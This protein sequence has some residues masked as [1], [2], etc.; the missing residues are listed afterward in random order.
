MWR[1][2]LLRRELL[3][4][5]FTGKPLIV[6][7]IENECLF[8]E[9]PE[10]HRKSL[11]FWKTDPA[12]ESALPS[13]VVVQDDEIT[14][15]FASMNASISGP[16]PISAFC[17]VLGSS[18]AKSYSRVR[19]TEP[20]KEVL[21]GLISLS[22]A[23]ATTYAEGKIQ[24]PDLT[25]A[26]C[27]RTLSYGWA[28]A[29]ISGVPLEHLDKFVSSWLEAAS[30]TSSA[31]RVDV[32]RRQT[33]T[34]V[35]ILR[36]AGTLFYNAYVST[37]VASL[38]E[39]LIEHDT[40]LMEHSWIKLTR[41]WRE[42]ISLFEF[43]KLTREERSG[44]FLHAL[45][46]LK[47]DATLSGYAPAACGFLATQISPGSFEHLPFLSSV[48]DRVA[49]WYSFMT[50]LQTPRGI[51]GFRGG[52]GSRILR[53]ANQQENFIDGPIGDISLNELRILARG[54]LES[55]AKRLSHSNEIQVEVVPLVTCTFRFQLSQ[56]RQHN[57]FEGQPEPV[58]KKNT[59]SQIMQTESLR[60]II[61]MTNEL[62]NSL[63]I[64]LNANGTKT[65]SKR[66]RKKAG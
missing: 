51:L 46:E 25:P 55:L 12:R 49:F 1:A 45:E 33:T 2:E 53:D 16:S 58:E 28:K 6:P 44:F 57:L 23:E 54:G 14:D 31:T 32:I 19:H 59:T 63:G 3:E 52:L 20:V 62:A 26:I 18:E 65:P 10:L 7:E 34:L 40:P 11:A 43:E 30:L 39:G 66:T 47:S 37:G 13:V 24:A 29:L 35:E 4:V 36:L 42:R 56:N 41:D 9:I 50:G 61:A 15:F 8:I 38:C 60:K 5:L 21:N 17:R 48:N 22:F 64:D 27:K